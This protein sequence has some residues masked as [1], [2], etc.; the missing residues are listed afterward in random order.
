MP[1]NLFHVVAFQKVRYS[2]QSELWEFQFRFGETV[3]TKLRPHTLAFGLSSVMSQHNLNQDKS[4]CTP[5]W[6]T[7]YKTWGSHDRE[8]RWCAALSCTA[9]PAKYS[10]PEFYCSWWKHLLPLRRLCLPT[11]LRGVILQKAVYFIYTYFP[12][13]IFPNTPHW[14]LDMSTYCRIQNDHTFSLSSSSRV[15]YLQLL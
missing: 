4:W 12:N 2:S 6:S 9:S 14:Q 11:N 3:R 10:Y 8:Y 7:L 15:T 1:V 13:E 5:A